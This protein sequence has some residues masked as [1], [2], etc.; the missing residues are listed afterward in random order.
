M[1]TKQSS[2]RGQSKINSSSKSVLIVLDG[3]G[4]RTSQVNNA[5]QKAKTPCF[6]SLWKKNSHMLLDASGPSVGLPKSVIGNSE[7]GHL[8]LGAGRVIPQELVL[9]NRSIKNGSFFKNKALLKSIT[10]VKKNKSK[11]HLLGLFS[12][13]GVHAHINHLFAILKLMGSK[14]IKTV[15]FHPILDGRDVPP[16]SALKYFD[17][18]GK[19][20]RTLKIKVV[21]STIIGRY[22]GMDRDHRW[23]REHRA[24]ESLVSKKDHR[25]KHPGFMSIKQIKNLIKDFYKK[26]ITDEFIPPTI[27]D[28]STVDKND[29]MIFFNFRGDRAREI[30]KAFVQGKFLEF[31]R[32]KIF[33]LDFV[34]LAQYDKKIK[35]PVAFPPSLPKNTLGEILFKNNKS[36]LRIAETEKYAH[37]TFFFNGGKETPFKK[38]DRIIIPSR[39]VKTYDE[40]PQMRAN[41][42][43]KKVVSQI[44]NK[45]QDFILINFSN[46][47]MVGH[48][49]Y[50]DAA[51]NAVQI[52][53]ACLE[54]VMKVAKLNNYNIIVTADHGNAEE[55]AGVHKTSH[56]TNK[57]PLILILEENNKFSNNNIKLTKKKSSIA[58]VAPTILKLMDLPI[59]NEMS[60]PLF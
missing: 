53:D 48:T 20:L 12:D 21:I 11:M 36:Q 38:E 47:D 59:P 60:Y 25:K 45:S 42:I 31:K 52:T 35:A 10:H 40:T 43:T 39:K 28:N 15:Y 55:M 46:P 51:I 24:Y 44:K 50:L 23:H 16:M 32:K 22:Y 13:A 19:K 9:I 34:C 1:T 57:V 18:L 33:D 41:E 27:T 26:G 5:I 29:S 17:L 56:T 8:H 58:N 30:T 14:G 6:D 7:V 2:K 37:V 49:G 54:K 3:W 4:I